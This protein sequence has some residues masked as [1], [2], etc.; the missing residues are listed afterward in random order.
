MAISNESN[1][2]SLDNS[3][4]PLRDRFNADKEKVRF[5]ALLSPT[6]PLWRDQGARAVHENIFKKY[7]D[8]DINAS[9][10]KLLIS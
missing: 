2:I 3:F 8:A 6:C 1:I 10:E 9:M 5:L 4:A 7:P